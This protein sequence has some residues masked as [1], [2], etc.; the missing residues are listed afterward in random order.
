MMEQENEAN[1][2]GYAKRSS[3]NEVELE[4]DADVVDARTLDEH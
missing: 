4:S 2:Y 1:L 3:E